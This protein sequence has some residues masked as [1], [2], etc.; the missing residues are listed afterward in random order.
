MAVKATNYMFIMFSEAKF[1]QMQFEIDEGEGIL[2]Q[3]AGY[4]D[5]YK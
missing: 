2:L 4:I 5:I 3:S 1:G